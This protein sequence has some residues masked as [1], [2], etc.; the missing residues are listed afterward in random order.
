LL[1]EFFKTDKT[2]SSIETP[3]VQKGRSLTGCMRAKGQRDEGNQ[4]MRFSAE[5]GVGI[6]FRQA[7]FLA[8]LS[9]RVFGFIKPSSQ[10]FLNYPV[11]LSGWTASSSSQLRFSK[12]I[13]PAVN[14][15]SST[16]AA[17][18]ISTINH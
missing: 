12:T 5:G 1:T 15:F 10:R 4:L 8:S 17:N 16:M 13:L 7:D 3:V 14:L 2:G 6:V 18:S 9:S 11:L